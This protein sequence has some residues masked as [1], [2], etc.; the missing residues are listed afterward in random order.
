MRRQAKTM[1]FAVIYGISDF[2][3]SQ[4]LGVPTGVAH[5]LIGNYF[6]RFPG[7]KKYTEDIVEATRRSGYVTTVLGRRRYIPDIR[8]ANRNMRLFAERMAV[9]T[10]IQG[11][12]SDIMKLAMIHVHDRLASDHND[13]AM[14]LQV[15]DE[16]VFEVPPT[17]IQ[18][19]ADAVKKTMEEA[20]PLSVPLKVD[21]KAGSNW[22][23]MV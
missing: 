12:A 22:A 17:K 11:S 9:N 8:S 3:L 15:H 23:E 19:F 5:E 7:V 18:D 20:Y 6:A 2:G 4:Q 14:I 10:P 21:V 16:L 1:N 13:T